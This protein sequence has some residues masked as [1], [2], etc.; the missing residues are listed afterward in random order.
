MVFKLAESAQKTWRKLNGY[1]L[2]A[3]VFRGVQFKD[4]LKVN[5]A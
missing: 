3:D 2:L 4:G 5:V 1:K